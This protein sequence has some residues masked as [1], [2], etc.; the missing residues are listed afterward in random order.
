MET[1][2]L[3]QVQDPDARTAPDRSLHRLLAKA[4]RYRA[5]MLE[6]SEKPLGE[7][8]AEVGVRTSRFI[9]GE[10]PVMCR[11]SLP[12]PCRR[13]PSMQ[14]PESW[15]V[16]RPN[17]RAAMRFKNNALGWRCRES[18]ANQSL[19]SLI[20]GKNTGNSQLHCGLSGLNFGAIVLL[21]T[22]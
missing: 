17:E 13:I 6:N 18:A 12:A 9:G 1:R 20:I 3:I 4:E 11:P 19:M 14:V 22:V 8:A 15:R 16:L 10:A 21:F 7:L 5:L 2:L